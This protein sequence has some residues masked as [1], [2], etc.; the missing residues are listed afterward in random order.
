MW[1]EM[2]YNRYRYSSQHDRMRYEY[3]SDWSADE[4]DEYIIEEDDC[5]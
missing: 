4:E 3:E 5:E 2:S 1:S